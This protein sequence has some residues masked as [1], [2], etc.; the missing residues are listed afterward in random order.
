MLRPVL[1][2]HFVGLRG[3][4]TQLGAEMARIRCNIVAMFAIWHTLHSKFL[5]IACNGML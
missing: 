4:Y 2:V 5:L 3:N 1:Q